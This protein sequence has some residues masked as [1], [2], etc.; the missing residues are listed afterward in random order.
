MQLRLTIEETF[1]IC[2]AAFN[3]ATI[4]DT[5]AEGYDPK[6]H[7]LDDL[8]NVK[9]AHAHIREGERLHM[10][11]ANGRRV[12]VFCHL[13]KEEPNGYHV[14]NIYPFT[15]DHS[16]SS[17]DVR[18]ATGRELVE[19]AVE[20]V[21]DRVIDWDEKND[22]PLTLAERVLETIDTLKAA[23]AKGEGVEIATV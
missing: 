3:H 12:N 4:V 22:G 2:V 1:A 20:G 21:E 13:Q 9:K 15:P 11:D 19:Y 18:F 10:G 7:S 23:R 17:W 8:F 16:M 5:S 14:W 6:E